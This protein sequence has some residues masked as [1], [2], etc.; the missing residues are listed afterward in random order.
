M[1]AIVPFSGR[2]RRTNQCEVSGHTQL[3]PAGRS[4]EDAGRKGEHGG[5]ERAPNCGESALGWE[6]LLP[7]KPGRPGHGKDRLQESQGGGCGKWG[8]G[9]LASMSPPA[10]PAPLLS[11]N[12]R[13]RASLMLGSS[14]PSTLPCGPSSGPSWEPLPHS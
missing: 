9:C 12:L 13:A 10:P 14:L 1:V 8:L 5:G 7:Q 6:P 3:S 2:S 4:S 11:S